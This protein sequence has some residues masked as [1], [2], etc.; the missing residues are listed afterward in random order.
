MYNFNLI[1]NETIVKVFH[2]V[3]ISQGKNR[4]TTTV[5]VTNKRIL[6]LEYIIQNEGLELLRFAR[7]ADYMR[8]KEV[9]YQIELSI[10]K[11]IIKNKIYKI[12]LE[13]GKSFEIENDELYNILKK[14]VK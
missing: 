12:I 5:A 9:Y 11:S 3:L 13:D 14:L 2:D 10:I 1:E 4:K 6:F 7:G 8:C